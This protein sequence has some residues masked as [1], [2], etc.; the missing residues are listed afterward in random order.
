MVIVIDPSGKV[1]QTAACAK[2]KRMKKSSNKSEFL[3]AALKKTERERDV[4]AREVTSLSAQFQ[5][6]V[7]E[8]SVIRRVNETLKYMLDVRLV[9][10]FILDI[11]LE[12][13]RA[14]TS[15]IMLY[16]RETETLSI[17]AAKSQENRTFDFFDDDSLSD[18]H[19]RRGEGIAGSVVLRK[20]TIYVPD[21]SKDNRYIPTSKYG[22]T[23]SLLCLPLVINNQIKGVVN[24]RHPN[25]NAFETEDQRLITILIDQAAVALNSVNLFDNLQHL[26]R[27]LEEKINQ[28]THHLQ[29]SNDQLR[30]EILEHEETELALKIAKEEAESTSKAKSEFLANMSHE[31][32]TPLNA[33]IGIAQIMSETHLD[34]EQQD[35]LAIIKTSAFGLLEL[36]NRV[37]DYSKIES[38]KYE[39]TGE[40]IN[41]KSLCRDV[42]SLFTVQTR[43]K[44]ISFVYDI[45]DDLP[46]VWKSDSG[47]IRQ[48]L[49]NILGNAV[50]FT[51]R[52]EVKLHVSRQNRTLFF[53]VSDTGPG[54]PV[55]LQKVIFEPFR[56]VDGLP[57]K[58]HGGTGLGLSISS[59]LVELLGG[60]VRL[61]STVSEGS[62]FFFSLPEMLEPIF[63]KP[64]KSGH[65]T[66]TFQPNQSLSILVIED[67]EI[68]QMIARKMLEKRGHQVA[69]AENAERG[70]ALWK[71]GAFDIVLMDLQMP[72]MDGIE[73]TKIIRAYE[74]D[75]MRNETPIVAV[76]AHALNEYR[77]A[78]VAAGMNG[79]ISKPFVREFFIQGIEHAARRR[80]RERI[81]FVVTEAT[82]N[83]LVFDRDKALSQVA[84]DVALFRK[85]CSIF[86]KNRST[87]LKE[88][89]VA[90]D[91]NDFGAIMALS[92]RVK[93]AMGTFFA[94]EAYQAANHMECL[95]K[96][97][98]RDGILAHLSILE[99]KLDNLNQIFLKEGLLEADQGG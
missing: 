10:N 14:E 35:H 60:V 70:I 5:E 85:M 98:D 27:T 7:R 87:I 63:P 52:G 32:R 95:A 18:F 50:K 28:A 65:D 38:K 62:T 9:F 23:G 67:N 20:K 58:R 43:Q 2:E 91:E 3:I 75:Q 66:M 17:R 54:I 6:K 57:A 21:I 96:E 37:L 78:C 64:I 45:A 22:S 84:G 89:R 47:A 49:T 12:E 8:L 4:Y 26:N 97:M 69:V 42:C 33:V 53:A 99:Q 55:E 92:H 41:I 73:A 79:F 90:L 40:E 59:Y 76:T 77:D 86:N 48:V 88:M 80:D 56:Q 11:I 51:D 72:V 93:G 16:D 25:R 68:N 34:E 36:I 19:L 1:L 61:E 29:E 71:N 39:I 30:Q 81:P 46:Q 94:D 83:G 82:V 15:S 13:T 31:I 74:R 44:G 24:L